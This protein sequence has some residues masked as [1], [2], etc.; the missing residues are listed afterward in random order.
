MKTTI[1]IR[2]EAAESH[3]AT[4]AAAND[5]KA[6]KTHVHEMSKRYKETARRE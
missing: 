2:D 5:K 1:R 6:E 4:A 3:P